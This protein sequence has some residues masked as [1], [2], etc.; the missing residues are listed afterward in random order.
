MSVAV[1]FYFV[2]IPGTYQLI[3]EEKTWYDAEEHC[4]QLN[5]YLATVQTPSANNILQ[6]LL[7]DRLDSL[8]FLSLFVHVS[9]MSRNEHFP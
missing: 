6:Q 5:T 9:I 1:N 2:H 7:N 8:F 4:R 3:Q